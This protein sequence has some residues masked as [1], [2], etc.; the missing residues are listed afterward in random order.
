MICGVTEIKTDVF[1]RI[2][3]R[4]NLLFSDVMQNVIQR[5]VDV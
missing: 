3:T 1:L 4:K 5:V 2:E